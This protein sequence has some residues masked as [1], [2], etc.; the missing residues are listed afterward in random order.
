MSKKRISKM[1]FSKERVELNIVDDLDK[2]NT[3]YYRSIDTATSRIKG[4]LSEARATETKLDEAIKAANKMQGI[5]GKVR[6]MAQELGV[7]PN[8][9]SE[10][11]DAELAI[12]RASEW[13]QVLATI[14]K[15]IS[16]I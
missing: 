5:V 4:L 9:I 14:K 11:G 7:N 12:S 15:F 3:T 13:K 16:S 8:N 2:L 10:L 6:K 1:L